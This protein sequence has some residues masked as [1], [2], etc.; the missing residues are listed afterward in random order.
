MESFSTVWAN[1]PKLIK[2]NPRI[3]DKLIFILFQV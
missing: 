1:A 2:M 3:S